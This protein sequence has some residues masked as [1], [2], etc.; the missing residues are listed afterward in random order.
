M[1]GELHFVCEDCDE[2][3]PRGGSFILIRIP[4]FG[5]EDGLSPEEDTRVVCAECAEKY[6]IRK[7]QYAS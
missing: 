6:N 4:D 7:P 3:K 2:R 1:L 5:D